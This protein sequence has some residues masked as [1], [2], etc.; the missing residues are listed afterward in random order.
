M[1]KISNKNITFSKIKNSFPVEHIGSINDHS[2]LEF[3]KEFIKYYNSKREIIEEDRS[4]GEYVVLKKFIEFAFENGVVPLYDE[5]K[6]PEKKARKK[7]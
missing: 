5:H 7:R 1:K 6:K 4:K 2:F 3:K